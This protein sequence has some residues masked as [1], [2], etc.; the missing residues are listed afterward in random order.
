MDVIYKYLGFF[1]MEYQRVRFYF[2]ELVVRSLIIAIRLA[3]PYS[4]FQILVR[5][6]QITQ[7]TANAMLWAVL[8]GQIL[9]GSNIRLHT[10][11]RDEI[12]NGDISIRISEPVNY[13]LAKLSQ[14][15]GKFLPS[16]IAMA[17]IFFPILFYLF[18]S[19][20]NVPLLILFTLIS[21]AVT[22]LRN[23]IVGLSS[24]VIEGNDGVFYIVSKL[25]LIF[26]NQIIPIALMPLWTIQM[27]KLTPFYYGLAAP[28]EA[29]SGRLN[30]AEGLVISLVYI[31]VLYLISQL[32]L[33]KLRKRLIL[34]G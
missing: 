13:V 5:T 10:K 28:I 14:S 32:M 19:K 7:A 2:T 29:A 24:F 4:I 21:F 15:F 1:L 17:A 11:V 16:F 30:W 23:M 3:L 18:P 33:N 26:G 6:G 31:V 22:N 34:N 12:R 27:A 8:I 25:F 9:Y 20:V